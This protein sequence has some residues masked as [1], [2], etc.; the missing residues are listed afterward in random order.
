MPKIFVSYSS[1]DQAKADQ[2]C[3]A[4]ENAGQPCWIA[5]RDLCAGTQWGAGIVEAIKSCDAVVVVF[6]Q[7][8]N[9]SPQ[10]AR[11]MELAV[12][13]R[14]PL[15]PI[16][17]ADDMP[18]DDMQYFLGVSHWFNAYA[19]PLATYLPDIVTAVKNVAARERSPWANITRRLPRSRNT[20]VLLS[21]GA[22]ALVAVVIGL[23]LRTPNPM[24]AMSSPMGGRWESHI[25]GGSGDCI[26]DVPG[27]APSAMASFSDGC[28]APL[29]S[30]SG[31][32]TAIRDPTLAPGFY[33]SGDSGTFMAQLAGGFFTGA[34]KKGFFGGLTTRDARFGEIS[35]TRAAADTPVANASDAVLSPSAPWPLAEVPA[36]VA[37]AETF[38]RAHWERDAV[39]MSLGLKPGMSGGVQ[40][41]FTFYS[42][43]SQQGRFFIPNMSGAGLMAPYG[44]TDNPAH[45]IPDRFLDLPLAIARAQQ[46]GMRGKDV[47]EAQ[48][49]WS[50]GES[51]GTGNFRIDNAILPKC[52][53][54]RYIGLQWQIDAASGQ[55]YFVP[56]AP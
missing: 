19:K 47:A 42:P 25:P 14:R 9:A 37:R 38:I 29:T 44:H 15:I 41:T 43:S 54:G 53:P 16:R 28:P 4:L 8:A 21:L 36:V 27:S 45:A 10:V 33:R 1:P 52:R 7:A 20:Q 55:R 26:M 49:Q 18:T 39:L 6:S 13:N 11:E 56:A 5:P 30:T 34:F 51:C 17:V 22:A 46:A 40:A 23:L 12:A 3:A 24:A 48:L 2:I 50:G 35:W 31:L 32:M